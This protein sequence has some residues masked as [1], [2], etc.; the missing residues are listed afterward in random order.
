MVVG[1][2]DVSVFIEIIAVIQGPEQVVVLVAPLPERFESADGRIAHRAGDIRLYDIDENVERGVADRLVIVSELA[3]GL[4]VLV[5]IE[6][7][8]LV[9]ILVRLGRAD[10]SELLAICTC[11]SGGRFFAVVVRTVGIL[12]L[13]VVIEQVQLTGEI[14]LSRNELMGVDI[15]IPFA[16]PHIAFLVVEQLHELPDPVPVAHQDHIRDVLV[17]IETELEL[18][19]LLGIQYHD[20]AGASCEHIGDIKGICLIVV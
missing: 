5:I 15:K 4:T 14:V 11:G 1:E 12:P 7:L 13:A 6:R 16:D 19:H 9:V 2:H 18:E 10:R 3:V 20:G 17:V 8:V